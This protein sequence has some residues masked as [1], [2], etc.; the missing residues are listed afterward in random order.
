M[1]ILDYKSLSVENIIFEAPIKTKNNAYISKAFLKK[2]DGE[3]EDVY[4]QTP[5]L[6]NLS[7]IH[8]TQQRAFFDVEIDQKHNEFYQFLKKLDEQNIMIIQKNSKEW[9]QQDFPLDVVEQFYRGVVHLGRDQSSPQMKLSLP[10]ED[11]EI[12]TEFFDNKRNRIFYKDV[13]EGSK[14]ITVMKFV[15]LRFLQQNVVCVW[16]PTQIM[17]DE[18][19]ENNGSS[20]KINESLLSDREVATPPPSPTKETLEE[21]EQSEEEIE[22]IVLEEDPAEVV[23]ST[24]ESTTEESTTEEPVAEEPTAEEPTTEEPTAEEPTAEESNEEILVNED[25]RIENENTEFLENIE[26][27]LEEQLES[28]SE[29]ELEDSVQTEKEVQTEDNTQ[30]LEELRKTVK[31]QTYIIEELRT[32]LNNIM[33]QFAHW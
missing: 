3:K 12:K 29:T 15:G 16:V 7:G 31:K 4:I 14:L 32:N 2:E 27:E 26:L 1:N 11:E 30:E 22:E 24:E 17:V 13:P 9:F 28:E 5:R 21:R 8:K 18:T 20:L 25:E 23:E 19:L 10:V 6:R 33:Q